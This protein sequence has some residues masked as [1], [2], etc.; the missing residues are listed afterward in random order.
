VRYEFILAEH[1]PDVAHAAFPELLESTV[2]IG[3]TGSVMFGDVVDAPHLHGILDR[4]Q[5]LG[6]TLLELRRLPD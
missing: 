2:E 3:S 5:D 6:L 4:F 1:M